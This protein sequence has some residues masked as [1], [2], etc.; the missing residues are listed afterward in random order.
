MT[1][2]TGMGSPFAARLR[3]LGAAQVGAFTGVDANFFSFVDE[4]WNLDHEAGFGLGGFGDAGGCRRLQSRL[5]FD[6]F[7]VDGLRQF[8]SHRLAIEIAH[9]NLQVRREV[10]DG[11]A[12]GR[13]LEHGL[14][15]VLRVHEVV[16][17]AVGVEELHEDFVDDH[18][19][20]GVGGAEAVLE[21]GAG[22][23]VAQLGLDEGAKIAGRAV[24]DLEDRVQLVI[25][26][27]DHARTKLSGG[28]RHKWCS[29]LLICAR[30]AMKYAVWPVLYCSPAGG[31]RGG[32]RRAG[33]TKIRA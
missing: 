20:N 24:L 21:H 22:L 23:Q 13:A 2:G 30:R 17:V 7:E 1:A 12:K 18:L 28:N 31:L 32:S 27:D 33:G 15:E 14:L 6:D 4:G 8:N 10:F 5:G 16:I 25:V 9:V 3:A 26:F 29:S 11:V 19:L